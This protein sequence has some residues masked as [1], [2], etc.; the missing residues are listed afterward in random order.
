ML[1]NAPGG[2]NVGPLPPGGSVT[3][4][5]YFDVV[6]PEPNSVVWSDGMRDILAWVPGEPQG[7]TRP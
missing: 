2:L 4:K 6:G 7:G 5:L 1:R 3:G